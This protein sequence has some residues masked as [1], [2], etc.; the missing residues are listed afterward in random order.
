MRFARPSPGRQVT[1]AHA[2]VQHAL[3]SLDEGAANG[4]WAKPSRLPSA[5]GT[6]PVTRTRAACGCFH[7]TVGGL[8]SRNGDHHGASRPE[9]RIPW[10]FTADVYWTTGSFQGRTRLTL[11]CKKKGRL[12]QWLCV[13]A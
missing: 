13:W 6:Q 7:T 2:Q 5:R 4:S 11:L 10:P 1:H 12:A 9:I 3:F 8:R